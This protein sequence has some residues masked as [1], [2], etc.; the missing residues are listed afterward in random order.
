MQEKI[1]YK[2]YDLTVSSAG[3]SVKSTFELDK[4]VEKVLG[5]T[6]TADREDQLYHRGS[7]YLSLNGEEILPEGYEAKLLIAGLGVAPDARYYSREMRPGNGML[8]VSYQDTNHPLAAFSPYRV[9]VYVKCL[10]KDA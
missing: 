7:L 10:M 3:Q 6:L 8:A 2:R 1:L 9:S 4:T 5:L